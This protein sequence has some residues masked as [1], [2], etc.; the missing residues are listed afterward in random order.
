MLTSTSV[1]PM[2]QDSP[3]AQWP[4]STP[5]RESES[6]SYQ[7]SELQRSYHQARE[8]YHVQKNSTQSDKTGVQLFTHFASTLRSALDTVDGGE[9]N[10]VDAAVSNEGTTQEMTDASMQEA[11]DINMMDTSEDE[12]WKAHVDWVKSN[13]RTLNVS[14]ENAILKPMTERDGDEIRRC[15]I[16]LSRF[17]LEYVDSDDRMKLEL[18]EFDP[19]EEVQ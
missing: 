3:R 13:M 12:S 4:S 6:M 5:G 15:G 11:D 14:L 16:A 9:A 19:F 8:E 2:M 7:T 1:S 18:E 17:W 10:T